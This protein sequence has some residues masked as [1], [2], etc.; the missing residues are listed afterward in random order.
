MINLIPNC[1]FQVGM[2]LL[3]EKVDVSQCP[4]GEMERE[5][6]WHFVGIS[7]NKAI[8]LD[9]HDHKVIREEGNP[10]S[11]VYICSDPHL[12]QSLR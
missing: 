8:L 10:Y 9:H 6:D 2:Q 7:Y 3:G 4:D 1:S 11:E 12:W 5:V